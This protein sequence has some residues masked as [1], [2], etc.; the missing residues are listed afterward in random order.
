VNA[1]TAGCVIKGSA[2]LL[3][4]SRITAKPHIPDIERYEGV[5]KDAIRTGSFGV[6]DTNNSIIVEAHPNNAEHHGMA[7]M[8]ES[9]SATGAS[10][11]E[12]WRLYLSGQIVYDDASHN[13]RT[14]YFRRVY[15]RQ[16]GHF[17]RTGDPD[18]EAT[19]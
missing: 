10:D 11:G 15:D 2:I 13:S 8:A 5:R 12:D 1:G 6:G 16:A 9:F 3:G 14:T 17:V 7:Q 19:Y 4:Y 18:D